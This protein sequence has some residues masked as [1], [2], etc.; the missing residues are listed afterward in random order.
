VAN[1]PKRIRKSKPDRTATFEKRTDSSSRDFYQSYEWREFR[2]SNKKRTRKRDQIRV[3]E[4]YNEMPNTTFKSLAAWMTD[5]KGS[6]LCMHCIDEGYLRPAQVADHIVR[7]RDGGL[8][9]SHS[10][11]QW[12]CNHHHNKKSGKEAHE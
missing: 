2:A 6:P 11:I 8:K 12:L 9:L 7:I 5:S 10:N 4:L 3:H 1:T